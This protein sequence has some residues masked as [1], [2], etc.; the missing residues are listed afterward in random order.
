MALVAGADLHFSREVDLA[1]IIVWDALIDPVLLEGWLG[2]VALEPSVDGAVGIRWLDGSYPATTAGRVTAFE[3]RTRLHV[4]TDNR[5]SFAFELAA[6]PGGSRGDGTVLGL[7]VCE[8]A[9]A[10][11]RGSAAIGWALALDR[12]EE[13]LR[14]HPVRWD[15]WRATHA[16]ALAHMSEKDNIR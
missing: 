9:G 2:D 16:H 11:A 1:P 4:V 5:G 15:D 10:A 6:V 14:G 3:H 7:T 13:L 8:L 12:L